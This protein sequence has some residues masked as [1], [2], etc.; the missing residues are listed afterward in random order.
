[1]QNSNLIAFNLLETGTLS[2]WLIGAVV[3]P[4]CVFAMLVHRLEILVQIRLAERFGW[5]IVLWTGWLGTPLHE[6]SH[7]AMCVLFRHKIIEM[8]L[9]EPDLKTG[10]LGYVKHS[11]GKSWYEEVGNV[12]I[13]MA[14]LM[15]GTLGLFFLLLMFYP[16]VLKDGVAALR[17][18]DSGAT[19]LQATWNATTTILSGICQWTHLFTGR[20][21]LFV[22]LVLCVGTHMAPSRSDYEGAKRGVYLLAGIVFAAVALVCLLMGNSPSLFPAVM[23]LMAPL[24]ALLLLAVILCSVAAGVIFLIT[25]PIPQRYTFKPV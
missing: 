25:I 12:F 4:L 19:T 1:M 6:L 23:E 11:W 13:G 10:R 16:E 20:F 2:L 5:K 24:V 14:P 17:E 15:G 18:Q 9:F 7:A 21:W 8:K 3:L 22:Y